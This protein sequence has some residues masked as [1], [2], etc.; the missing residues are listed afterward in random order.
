QHLTNA[1]DR[2][3]D[4]SVRLA[5]QKPAWVRVY[6]RSGL[7]GADQ[8]LRAVRVRGHGAGRRAGNRAAHREAQ[9]GRR[10]QRDH[11]DPQRPSRRPP[12]ARFA[13]TI[14]RGSG[15]ATWEA[16]GARECSLEFSLQFS[17]DAGRSWNGLAVGLTGKRHTFSLMR[18]PSGRLIFRVL[19]HDGFHTTTAVSRAVEIPRRAP[20][21]SILSPQPGRPYYAGAPLRLWGAVT[22]DDGALADPEGCSW[23]IGDRV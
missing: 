5:A 3:P 2:G 10:A 15:R 1:D 17:K 6:V 20:I 19:A 9:R 12:V 16:T 18:L 21:V 11:L 14:T 13:V 23:R 22:E 8:D 4:N 7:L